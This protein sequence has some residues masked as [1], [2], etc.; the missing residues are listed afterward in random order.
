MNLL[1]PTQIENI[2]KHVPPKASKW[3]SL[4]R[5]NVPWAPLGAPVVPRALFDDQKY[6]SS[7]PKVPTELEI[8]LKVTTRDPKRSKVTSNVQHCW[9]LAWRTTRRAYNT[10]TE[11]LALPKFEIWGENGPTD[12]PKKFHIVYLPFVCHFSVPKNKD[13]NETPQYSS[14][15]SIAPTVRTMHAVQFWAMQHNCQQTGNTAQNCTELSNTYNPVRY[16][17]IRYS[18]V[19]DNTMQ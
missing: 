14:C 11:L 5:A 18:T 7:I 9:D 17:T 8:P 19:Q 2:T 13:E 15:C 16:G 1:F 10:T 3:V 6:S 4:F 12:P